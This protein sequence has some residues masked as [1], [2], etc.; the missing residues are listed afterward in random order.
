MAA[1]A[2]ELRVATGNTKPDPLA[3]KPGLQH[4]RVPFRTGPQRFE[5]WRG[6]RCVAAA[7]APPIEAAITHYNFITAAGAAYAR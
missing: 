4:H 3:V 1:T 7:D 6:G 5:L 2:A